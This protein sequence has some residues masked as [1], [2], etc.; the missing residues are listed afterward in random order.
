VRFPQAELG[1]QSTLETVYPVGAIFVSVVTTNPATLL[2]FG[3]WAAF[4]AGRCLV[5]VDA[6]DA[7]FDAAEKTGGAKTVT[8][9]ADQSGVPAHGH[10]VTDAGH[11][12]VQGVN[13]ATTGGLAGYTPDTSTNTRVN[14]GYSTS[15][16]TTGISVN[17][18]TPANAAQAHSNVQPFIAVYLWKRTA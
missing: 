2:G 5:G 4:G 3:T 14:S 8:L 18:S 6:G 13:S 11:A 15:S 12:H 10:G 7:D 17:N 1:L 9:T 16:A